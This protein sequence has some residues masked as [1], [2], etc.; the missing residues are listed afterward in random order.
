ML[1]LVHHKGL[2]YPDQLCLGYTPL[3]LVLTIVLGT[4]QCPGI[5][6][7]AEVLDEHSVW[8]SSLRRTSTSEHEKTED[9]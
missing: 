9:G 8:L 5:R 4:C 2:M 6:G 7:G 3:L 1:Q